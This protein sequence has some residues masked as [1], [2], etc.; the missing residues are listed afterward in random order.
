MALFGLLFV[1]IG[2]GLFIGK[3]LFNYLGVVIPLIGAC[4]GIYEDFKSL[5][6][7][8]GLKWSGKNSGDLIIKRLTKAVNPNEMFD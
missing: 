3:R 1:V 7:N 8:Y 2:I 4:L 6:K 5:V